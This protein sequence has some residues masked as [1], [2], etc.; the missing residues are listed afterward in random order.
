MQEAREESNME[1]LSWRNEQREL[2]QRHKDEYKE[3]IK[4]LKE[5]WEKNGKNQKALIEDWTREIEHNTEN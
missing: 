2:L 1:I 3:M 4:A 5:E